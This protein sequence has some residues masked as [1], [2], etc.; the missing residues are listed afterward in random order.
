MEPIQLDVLGR[1]ISALRSQHGLTQSDLADRS[2]LNRQTISLIEQGERPNPGFFTL[3][4]IAHTF[5]LRLED[6]ILKCRDL[7]SE[8]SDAD[9]RELQQ[10]G[11][12]R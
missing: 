3:Q 4:K 5:E 12:S 8:T 1:C 9:N 7:Q 10:Q 6:L 2:G 11:R